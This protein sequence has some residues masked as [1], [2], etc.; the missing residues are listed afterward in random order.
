MALEL[1]GVVMD[2]A[3]P[4]AL[5]RFWSELLGRSSTEQ[6]RGVAVSLGEQVDLV[7]VDAVDPNPGKNR[8]HFDLSS[9]SPD[10]QAELV[11]RA[12]AL[13]AAPVDIGQGAVPWVVLA[14]PEGNEFCVLEPREEYMACGSVAALVVDALDP[15]ALAAFWSHAT[16]LPMTREHP[17]YATVR[18]E[19]GFWLEFVRVSEPKALPNRVRLDLSPVAD[20]NVGAE[21]ARLETYGAA[22]NQRDDGSA[23]LTDPEKN[24]FSVT[25][26][27]GISRRIG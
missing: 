1:R 12:R 17:E 22:V 7:L 8:L 6:N 5:G 15:P 11:H 26:W 18:R 27:R 19:S 20:G 25:A 21:L 9:T 3:D 14:D 4:V 2:S 24:E 16:G 10:H 13:G 23:V